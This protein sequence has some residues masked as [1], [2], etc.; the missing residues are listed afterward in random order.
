MTAQL[1]ETLHYQGRQ[2]A[3]CTTPLTQFLVISDGP[4]FQPSSTA[5]WR[6]YRGSWE[7][8]DERL[9]L[10]ALS[11]TL[12]NGE[13]AT[14]ATLFPNFPD[15]VF[16][17]WYNGVIR[18]P[19]G[20]LLEYVHAGYASRYEQDLLL[21]FADGVLVSSQVRQNGTGSGTSDSGG[22]TIAAM[23]TLTT[24]PKDEDKGQ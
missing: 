15:R 1:A 24:A 14:L 5:L 22:Y 8:I 6:G 3:M 17:H 13:Q 7:I 12:S 16:A 21:K 18:I 10:I 2:L 9:Y 4:H 11:G 23:T 19:Q 20:Q